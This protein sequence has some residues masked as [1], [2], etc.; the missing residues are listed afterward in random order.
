MVRMP[1][2]D[3]AR[4]ELC[5]ASQSLLKYTANIP[6]QINHLGIRLVNVLCLSVVPTGRE[7]IQR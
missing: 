1:L 7:G 6:L 5:A 3:L 4:S 2:L